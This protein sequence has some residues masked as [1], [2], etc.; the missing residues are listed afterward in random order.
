MIYSESG[1]YN[2]DMSHDLRKYARQTEI[3]SVIAFLIIL[4]VI[5]DG[6]IWLFYGGQSALFGALC[7]VAGLVP[8]GMIFGSLWLLD[9]IL[10]RNR[11]R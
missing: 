5:G 11:D 7:M 9:W 2:R 6:L 3:R 8:L 1:E 4:F 10:K